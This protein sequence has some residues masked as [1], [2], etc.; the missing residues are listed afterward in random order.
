MK[1]SIPIGKELEISPKAFRQGS[2][3]KTSQVVIKLT[4][5]HFGGKPIHL[6]YKKR[7]SRRA[8]G[9]KNQV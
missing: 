9:L 8:H 3:T 6:D 7:A 1:S 5:H 4:W 2:R